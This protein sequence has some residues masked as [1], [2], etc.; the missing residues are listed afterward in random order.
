MNTRLRFLFVAA[1]ALLAV[2]LVVG[3]VMGGNTPQE[4]PYKHLAVFTEVLSR[5]KS[6]YVEE[7]DMKSVTLGA[8]NGL[9][10][11]IDPCASYLSAEQYKTYLKDQET[12]KA[13]V[14]LVLARRY[15]YVGIVDAISGSPAARVGLTTGDV[16]E[17]IQGVSTRDMPLA[18]AEQLLR[19]DA[20]TSV[21][22]SVLRIRK[23]EPQK[24]T[25]VRAKVEY[26]AVVPKMLGGQTGY[27][28]AESLAGTR[29][30]EVIQAVKSLER[31]GAKKLILDLRHAATGTPDE[32]IAVANAFL[33]K[34][35]ITY[36]QG[37]K[38]PRKDFAADP[39]MTVSRLPL[40]VLTNRG[41]AGGAEVAAAALLDSKRAQV[42]GERTYGYAALRRAVT[43]DDGSAIILAVAKFYS[44]SGKAI[45]DTGVVPSVLS[46]ETE[47]F[48]D[49]DDEEGEPAKPEKIEPVKPPEEDPV[50]KKAI[51][52]LNG[53]PVQS[54]A[55]QAASQAPSIMP[56]TFHKPRL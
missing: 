14:G 3:S 19:G 52:V 32:G 28:A 25:L 42:V 55:G 24:I 11:A 12:Q 23:P 51:E 27:I 29:A 2:L 53:A 31:Q 43:V 54:A 1:S 20:G 7:P 56:E 4:G 38:Y 5:I 8:L 16:L 40:A 48:T 22:V 21:E 17:A 41:T 9:L 44:P 36:L 39:A 49:T 13:D 30:A 15:G 10:E 45:Q 50:V 18:Y 47:P 6:E 35:L 37:Q 46:V 26:P 34:G 33:E